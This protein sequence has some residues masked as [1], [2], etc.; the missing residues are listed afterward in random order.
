MEKFE[1][2][3]KTADIIWSAPENMARACKVLPIN[4]AQWG[5]D[6]AD[7]TKAYA[8]IAYDS[9]GIHLWLAAQESPILATKEN[10]NDSV[11]QDSCL[12]FFFSPMPLVDARYFNFECNPLG[13]I[14]LSLGVD[15]Q[16]R[17]LISLPD[18]RA[19]FGIQTVVEEDR[20][21]VSYTIPFAF[22]RRYFPAFTP[23]DSHT[24]RGNFYKCA[25]A[26]L[27]PHYLSW[28]PIQWEI[29]DFHRPECFGTLR[30]LPKEHL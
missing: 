27:H 29:P 25:D 17:E 9:D 15:R 5:Q 19:Y 4:E 20:W 14:Y 18:H 24:M 12:E 21:S 1:S 30:F 7:A 28:N 23:D 3:S 22:I 11:W 13:A 6:A 26:L 16:N 2:K 10:M 8:Q